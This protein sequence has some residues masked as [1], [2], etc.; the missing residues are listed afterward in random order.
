M[1]KSSTY[2]VITYFPTYLSIWNLLPTK[3]VNKVKSNRN[4]V[5]VHP[6]LGNSGHPVD[7]GLVGAGS[8][9][10]YFRVQI[11]WNLA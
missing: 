10:P 7:D 11:P 1:Y 6:Q 8:L 9:W 2:L 5:K 4:S 3:L